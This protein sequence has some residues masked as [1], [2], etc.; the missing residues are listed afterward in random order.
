LYPFRLNRLE[1][2][3]KDLASQILRKLGIVNAPVKVGVDERGILV[4]ECTQRVRIVCARP[5]Q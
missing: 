5:F 4:V 2:S 3:H 1:D